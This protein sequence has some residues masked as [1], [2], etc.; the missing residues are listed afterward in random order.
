[1][2]LIGRAIEIELL[3][4]ALTSDKSELVAV[5]GRRRVGKTF[6]I[7]EALKKELVFQYSGLYMGTLEEHMNI[8]A[9]TLSHLRNGMWDLPVPK[10]WFE[11]FRQLEMV[12]KQLRTKKKKVIFLDELPWMATHKSRFLTAFTHFWNQFASARKDIM[13]I[14]CGSAASWMINK[15]V[16]DKGGLHNRITKTIRLEPFNLHETELFF[17]KKK[18]ILDRYKITQLYMVMDGIPHYLD[19]VRNGESAVQAIDRLFFSEQGFLRQEYHQLFASLFDDSE[20]HR[21]V[22]ELLSQKKQGMSREELIE[23]IGIFSGGGISK[24]LE[25]LMESGFISRSI[26]FGKTLKDSIFKLTDNYTAFYH[27]YV[28]GSKIGSNKNWEKIAQSASWYSWSGL[29]FENLCMRHIQQVKKALRID[30]IKTEAATWH[31]KGNEEMQGAQIDMLIHRADGIINICEI[32]YSETPF[33]ITKNYA[34]EI[35][36][37]MASF[38]HFTKVKNT[39]FPTIIAP[40]GLNENIYSRGF[41]QNVIDIEQLFEVV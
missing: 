18:I 16:K 12:L 32:K 11:A 1:M 9:Q 27:K 10:N 31:H 19:Q 28:A 23:K 21:K 22:I 35:R 5:Y 39:L 17:K 30:G 36:M 40:Y 26:P 14:I 37:K 15:V 7:R 25:E 6:L 3:Q 13:I 38:R 2:E 34:N 29:A 41:I 33:T 24:I 8:F 4:E 20:K